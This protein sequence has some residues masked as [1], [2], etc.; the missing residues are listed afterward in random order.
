MSNGIG[1]H[2]A[3]SFA[4]VKGQVGV[5]VTYTRGDR[6]VALVA[7]PSTTEFEV[8]TG[9]V[10]EYAQSRDFTILASDLKFGGFA[11]LPERGDTIRESIEGTEQTHDVRAPAGSVHFRWLDPYR[12]VLKIHTTQTTSN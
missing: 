12:K 6:A 5:S 9:D 2:I 11:T 10:I 8:E 4:T 7:G 1:D 3:N